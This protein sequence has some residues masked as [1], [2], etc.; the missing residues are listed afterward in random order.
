MPYLVRPTQP[1]SFHQS[2]RR[3][4]DLPRQVLSHIREGLVF[5][6]ALEQTGSLGLVRIWA[7]GEALSVEIRGGL[8][9]GAT[10]DQVRRAFSLDLDLTA[11]HRHMAEADPIMSGL[12]ERFYGAR[13]ILPF[14]LW[15]ALAWTIIGQQVNIAF[16]YSL[17]ESLIRLAGRQ[18]EGRLAF[19]G[20]ETVAAFRYEDLQSQKFTRKKSEYIIDCARA[21]AAG[22]LDL[23]AVAALPYGAA[24]EALVSVR[25]VGRWTA[26]CVLMDAGCLDAF[27][28]DDIGI[29]NSVQR[30]YGLDRQP[31]GDEVRQIGRAW[32]PYSALACYYLWL[33]RRSEG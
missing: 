20:P 23:E 25:G 14:D 21:V 18:F 12:M 32:S 33:A 5:E 10:L 16:A 28:A 13:P 2:L 1:Y 15:E 31:T 24:L 8:E 4:Q 17:K 29:R 30:Y 3:L 26:E 9:P 27:P 22:T 19:P 7:S 11:V 6:R